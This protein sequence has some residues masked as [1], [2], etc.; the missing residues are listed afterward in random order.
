[1]PLLHCLLIICVHSSRIMS[2]V[3]MKAKQNQCI[4]VQELTLMYINAHDKLAHTGGLCTFTMH[5]ILHQFLWKCFCSSLVY[6]FVTHLMGS[7]WAW[8]LDIFSTSHKFSN[9]VSW[10][11]KLQIQ[12]FSPLWYKAII[13][14]APAHLRFHLRFRRCCVLALDHM[15]GHPPCQ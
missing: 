3:L 7:G 10:N 11:K 2:M 5:S 6:P 14:C 8:K 12:M 13:G 9:H 1:M 4:S 15:D